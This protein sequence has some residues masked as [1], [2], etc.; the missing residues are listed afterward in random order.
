MSVKPVM[1]PPG[2]ARLATPTVPTPSL[3]T[4]M[5]IGTVLVRCLAACNTGPVMTTRT[6]TLLSISSCARPSSRS[7]RPSDPRSSMVIV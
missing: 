5:T 6:S 2:R 4:A 1:L 3:L 7:S